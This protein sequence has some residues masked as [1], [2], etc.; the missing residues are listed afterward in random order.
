MVCSGLGA[1]EAPLMKALNAVIAICVAF[2]LLGGCGGQ[3][4][5]GQGVDAALDR[6]NK[7]G[8]SLG[9]AS[10]ATADDEAP[11][12]GPDLCPTEEPAENSPC[13]AWIG[14]RCTYG[15]TTCACDIGL[16]LAFWKCGHPDGGDAEA[17]ADE[18]AYDDGGAVFD[19]SARFGGTCIV[20]SCPLGTICAVEI[21]GV[22]GRGGAGTARPFRTG[23]AAIPPALVWVCACA[24]SGLDSRR[25]V[26]ITLTGRS[27]VT[28]GFARAFYRTD[29]R[30]LHRHCQRAGIP[31]LLEACSARFFLRYFSL[32]R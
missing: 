32:Q 14:A 1:C 17:G 6:S 22:A 4:A 25:S 21:G 2:A 3:T 27:R 23:A 26:W 18:C 24:A 29:E 13:D 9:A 30:Q 8:A 10:D 12:S 15:A 11:P 5:G 31:A 20:G 7:D 19:A 28:T 16:N